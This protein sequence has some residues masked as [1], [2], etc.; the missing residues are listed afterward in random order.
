MNTRHVNEIYNYF[1]SDGEDMQNHDLG[2]L[3]A[4]GIRA[5]IWY[6]ESKAITEQADAVTTHLKE[7][8]KRAESCRYAHM[9]R[10]ILGYTANNGG[11]LDAPDYG[12]YTEFGGWDFELPEDYIRRATNHANS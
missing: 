5:L 2:T 9:A 7:Q 6:A 8:N 10:A 11:K 3:P 1:M 4:G 12:T